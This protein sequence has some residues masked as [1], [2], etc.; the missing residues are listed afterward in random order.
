MRE[1]RPLPGLHLGLSSIGGADTEALVRDVLAHVE[2]FPVRHF[3]EHY[4]EMFAWLAQR[5]GRGAGWLERSGTS[6]E[7]LGR[8]ADFF[9]GARFLHIHRN[10]PNT[11]LSLR[12]HRY[13][14]LFASD[15]LDPPDAGE[16]QRSLFGPIGGD[17]DPVIRRLTTGL[18]SIPQF[19]EYWSW[20]LARGMRDLHKIEPQNYLPI[21]YE[22]LVAQP[23]E[24]LTR[25]AGFFGLRADEGWLQ[26]ASARVDSEA[27]PD[28]LSD[29]DPPLRAKLEKACRPGQVLLGREEG[30]GLDPT[31][32]AIRTAI[33]VRGRAG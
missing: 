6:I 33:A 26:K 10:G 11:A 2:T 7:L 27:A 17:D 21:R 1:W 32:G 18:P 13:I 14:G 30:D 31:F 24:T 19:G 29:L 20:M 4:Q 23:H 22:D 16:I 12:A 8:Y 5:F 28:R 3:R 25:I 9:P 15:H